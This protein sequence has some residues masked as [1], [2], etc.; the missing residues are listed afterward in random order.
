[1]SGSL[2]LAAERTAI[3]QVIEDSIGWAATKDKARLYE[4]FAQDEAL[5]YFSPSDAGNIAGYSAF[6]ELVEGFF[7]HDDFQ[8]VSFA[9]RELAITIGPAGDTA[10]FRARLD[11]RNTWQG[12][13]ANWE[14][15]RW[16]GVLCKR[17][18]RWVIV[19]MHFSFASDAPSGRA[20]D[21]GQ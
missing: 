17:D 18:G 19:Q 2:D 14:N 4:C 1:M 3:K 5:F 20:Q 10:W 15:A 13:P 9:V 16:T 12:R 11:D 21:A 8:A 6:Q 7:M